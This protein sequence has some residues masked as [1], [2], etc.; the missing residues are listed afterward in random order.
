MDIST[1]YRADID[2]LRAV[3]VIPVVLYHAGAR[4]FSGGYV[5][6]DVFFVISGYLITTILVQD[7]SAGR[8]SIARFYE[9]RIRRIFPALFVVVLCSSVIGHL[10]LLP[11]DLKSFAKSV[12]ATTLFISNIAFWRESGYFDGPAEMKPLLHTWSLA[13]EEQYYIAFPILLFLLYRFTSARLASWAITLGAL[14]SLA[15]SVWGVHNAPVATFYLLPTRAWELLVGSLLAIGLVPLIRSRAIAEFAAVSGIALILYAIFTFDQD[16]PFPGLNALAPCI[17]AALIIHSGRN[18]C[19]PAISRALSM[20]PVRFVGLI[21]YSLYLWHWPI[22]V[23]TKYVWIDNPPPMVQA[24]VVAASVIAAAMSWRFVEGPFRDRSRVSTRRI[25]VSAASVMAVA[26]AVAIPG[27]AGNGL[28]DRLPASVVK[29]MAADAYNDPE[30]GR[31]H[32][33]FAKRMTFEQLCVRGMPG[34]APSFLLVG[35]SHAGAVAGGIFEGARQAG[36]S[37]IQLTEAG[38]RPVPSMISLDAPEK[39]SWMN[40]LLDEALRD[41][42]IRTVIVV[43]YWQQAVNEYRYATPD[44]AEVPKATAIQLGLSSLARTYSDR[45]FLL[46]TAPPA[47]TIFGAS[48]A[49]RALLFG[50]DVSTSIPRTTFDQMHARYDAVLRALDREPNIDVVDITDLLCDEARCAGYV[51]DQLAY[52]DDNHLTNAAAL[53]LAPRFARALSV[54]PAADR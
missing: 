51:G 41:P 42:V 17:G 3:A 7:F 18:G 39:Y 14:V 50:K 43:A 11:D 45:R 44:G 46:M 36:V 4:W 34:R 32:L 24:S 2:G 9:R 30:R 13:V 37:G 38:Y 16:T 12:I 6:V 52:R 31:C 8:Y 25:F 26:I 5:G 1:R 47:A 29:V 15:L 10:I 48:P 23:F 40:G 54:V 19:S 20:T 27:I 53:R 49:A 35:D 21:S 33:A 22:I 28:P